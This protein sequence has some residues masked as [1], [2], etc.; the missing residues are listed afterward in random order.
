MSFKSNSKTVISS[1]AKTVNLRELKQ[2]YRPYR[3]QVIPSKE[4]SNYAKQNRAEARK[5][6]GG[7]SKF[8]KFGNRLNR[9]SKNSTKGFKNFKDI[10]RRPTQDLRAKIGYENKPRNFGRNLSLDK[11]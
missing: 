6:D 3:N 4:S 8:D 5:F 11:N 9:N 1:R 7:I 10:F 2:P